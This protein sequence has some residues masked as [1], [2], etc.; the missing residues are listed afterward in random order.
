MLDKNKR[1]KKR[2]DGKKGKWIGKESELERA[3]SL[4]VLM[5]WEIYLSFKNE[6]LWNYQAAWFVTRM[7]IPNKLKVEKQKKLI[8]STW[9]VSEFLIP[10]SNKNNQFDNK[11]QFFLWK[12][13]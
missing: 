2:G 4:V 9:F 8:V 11:A 6:V 3:Q 1:K 5:F 10:F 12:E 13:S 7:R